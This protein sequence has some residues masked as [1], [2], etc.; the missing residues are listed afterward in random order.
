MKMDEYCRAFG[1]RIQ[2]ARGDLLY[3]AE[4]LAQSIGA[5]VE[6]M[7]RLESGEHHTGFKTLVSIAEF[8]QTD[9]LKLLFGFNPSELTEAVEEAFDSV[10]DADERLSLLDPEHTAFVYLARHLKAA[11]GALQRAIAM[12]RDCTGSIPT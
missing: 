10:S 9:P 6:W 1:L 8:L 7:Q 11:L 5:T 3:S 4:H 2:E 12:L